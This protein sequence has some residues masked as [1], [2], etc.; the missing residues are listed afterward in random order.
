MQANK[1][2]Y[3]NHYF[4]F[5]NSSSQ[6]NGVSVSDA[7]EITVLVASLGELRK[8]K[9]KS[10]V[11]EI[12]KNWK[13]LSSEF[14][15]QIK[16]TVPNYFIGK[17][18]EET[19][20]KYNF[21]FDIN[22]YP[23]IIQLIQTE[24]QIMGVICLVD[25]ALTTDLIET[26]KSYIEFLP[27]VVS[28]AC[29]GI[30]FIGDS[31]DTP[32]TGISLIHESCSDFKAEIKEKILEFSG[33]IVGSLSSMAD[34]VEKITS[35][36]G[37]SRHGSF[38]EPQQS[39]LLNSNEVVNKLVRN[40]CK[41][42]NNEGKG[43]DFKIA[44]SSRMFGTNT[45]SPSN[46]ADEVNSNSYIKIRRKSSIEILDPF[47]HDDLTFKKSQGR[48]KKLEGDLLLMSGRVT[49]AVAAFRLSIEHSVV[50]EDYVWQA[51][52]LESYAASLFILL[53]RKTERSFIIAIATCPPE[54]EIDVTVTRNDPLGIMGT[55]FNEGT[56]KESS[57]SKNSN[58]D[59]AKDFTTKDGLIDLLKEIAKL[60]SISVLSYEKSELFIPQL[61]S[62][63]CMKRAILQFIIDQY[64]TPEA[65]QDLIDK[66]LLKEIHTAFSD[67][68]KFSKKAS[69]PEKHYR[70]S[71]LEMA[72][73]IHRGWTQ[74]IMSLELRELMRLSATISMLFRF[75]GYQRKEAFFLRQF[76][77]LIQP[78]LYSNSESNYSQLTSQKKDTI[79]DYSVQKHII[80]CLG[81]VSDLY[82]V[83]NSVYF[84]R[85]TTTFYQWSFWNNSVSD[86]KNILKAEKSGTLWVGWYHL[87]TDILKECIAI[88]E[89]VPS[90]PHA[91][92]SAFRLLRFL[93][94][95]ENT[96]EKISDT[97]KL[98]L[99]F[100]IK[101]IKTEQTNLL[102]YLE[103]V[104]SL[105]HNRY[106]L[107]ISHPLL[108]HKKTKKIDFPLLAAG[109]EEQ[110]AK[111]LNIFKYIPRVL[112]T[113]AVVVGDVF[114]NLLENIQPHFLNSFNSG[115]CD[116]NTSGKNNSD[117][118]SLFLYNPGNKG[119]LDK[120]R[121]KSDSFSTL[122]V[123]E[124]AYFSVTFKNPFSIP[125][126]LNNVQLLCE[127][128]ETKGQEEGSSNPS[129]DS[130][131]SMD[132]ENDY[133]AD[134]V[135]SFKSNAFAKPILS[136]FTLPPSSFFTTTLAIIPK[137]RGFGLILGVR[138]T[139]FN[140]VILNCL[141][142]E[143]PPEDRNRNHRFQ[144]V[145]R[146]IV[147]EYPSEIIGASNDSSTLMALTNPN[148]GFA[149]P[150]TVYPPQP[151]LDITIVGSENQLYPLSS[152]QINEGETVPIYVVLQNVGT[153]P[154]T[155]FRVRFYNLE[156]E[157]IKD[158]AE[159][160]LRK[161]HNPLESLKNDIPSFSASKAEPFNGTNQENK[162]DFEDF[163]LASVFK[164]MPQG[165]ESTRINPGQTL[166]LG[167]TVF[168]HPFCKGVLLKLNYGY[169]DDE[170]V[171][172]NQDSKNPSK[173]T[174][175]KS[176]TYSR[177]I[178]RVIDIQLSKVL[179]PTIEYSMCK[180]LPLP[181]GLDMSTEEDK[182]ENISSLELVD[183]LVQSV[184]L[185]QKRIS[186]NTSRNLSQKHSKCEND[187]KMIEI[188]RFMAKYFC[189]V[190]FNVSNASTSF[191]EVS[192]QIE[193][194]L[195]DLGEKKLNKSSG[196]DG[197]LPD[198]IIRV[199]KVVIP[200]NC[201]NF[202]IL[203]PISRFKLGLEDL[204]DTN[205]SVFDENGNIKFKDYTW[206]TD[207]TQRYD[208][209]DGQT[210]DGSAIQEAQDGISNLNLDKNGINGSTSSTENIG[211]KATSSGS[212]SSVNDHIGS[213]SL[214][215][216]YV[217]PKG[218]KIS[219]SQL[220]ENRVYSSYQY[221]LMKSIRIKYNLI[222]YNR[223]G[224]CNPVMFVKLNKRD[225]PLLRLNSLV[226]SSITE[227]KP[228]YFDFS[229]PASK[230]E[231]KPLDKAK[232]KPKKRNSLKGQGTQNEKKPVSG[233]IVI[234]PLRMSIKSF[235]P[236]IQEK[237]NSV[238]EALL[239]DSSFSSICH[240]MSHVDIYISIKN[241]S[242]SRKLNMLFNMRMLYPSGVELDENSLPRPSVDTDYNAN[243]LSSMKN[244]DSLDIMNKLL[245][246]YIREIKGSDSYRSLASV[247]NTLSMGS[248][249]CIAQRTRA[250]FQALKLA[251]SEVPT[252]YTDNK[253]IDRRATTQTSDFYSSYK[254]P[255][256]LKPVSNRL[257]IISRRNMS[258]AGDLNFDEK[259]PKVLDSSSEF[260]D[261]SFV[262]MRPRYIL[263][264]QPHS[265]FP[266]SNKT[267]NVPGFLNLSR[268]SIGNHR[269]ASSHETPI[270]NKK[271][272]SNISLLKNTS[273]KSPPMF[274]DPEASENEVNK[275]LVKLK[276]TKT[277]PNI[278]WRDI[279]NYK[280]PRI[281]SESQS[282]VLRLP[283]FV[284]SSGRYV[285]EYEVIPYN[286]ASKSCDSSD[287][288]QNYTEKGKSSGLNLDVEVKNV[289]KA[290]QKTKPQNEINLDI[291]DDFLVSGITSKKGTLTLYA[292]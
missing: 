283:V 55:I 130:N 49:E 129:S 153:V 2:N 271:N 244:L 62:E 213:S 6:Y 156:P 54:T 53:N 113:D 243:L 91:I 194:V 190:S 57:V 264:E 196:K 179:V 96:I 232:K 234:N 33:N 17:A 95:I 209:E 277:I 94:H 217:V 108:S 124:T 100:G 192:F 184:S 214:S 155:H 74:S 126:F 37:N 106:H 211:N 83:D 287:K 5:E 145:R 216:Q 222:D 21:I 35:K 187:Y 87:Q 250:A 36:Y 68:R 143:M 99:G 165:Q 273:N 204:K 188:Q 245:S 110:I 189:I 18:S 161:K 163:D 71:A 282:I 150:V 167:F 12:K 90:Y 262:Y 201:S 160:K 172:E 176:V 115:W 224:F 82:N 212:K 260:Q 76:L 134:H 65:L 292:L 93:S 56:S 44:D 135:I 290:K 69:N 97:E 77:L 133:D 114:N 193:L 3:D 258:L 48:I 269:P 52:A 20:I 30:D 270:L 257:N 223:I 171:D 263:N 59:Q 221:F 280:L 112:G 75:S 144:R 81:S 207:L 42:S 148:A 88:A 103:R 9:W 166:K 199:V 25:C 173:N 123:D 183:M 38:E 7:G 205:D 27:F 111:K 45:F 46:M 131:D 256:N 195:P 64:T 101:K 102:K 235:S 50:L 137:C 8:G 157:P 11:S 225:I 255:N 125:L 180:I 16:S 197:K 60:Y 247:S 278:F 141:L 239:L 284:V 208:L 121:A 109:M 98:S 162:R 116:N 117:S 281:D 272:I 253:F 168:G 32:V 177:E 267:K 43:F 236:Y 175:L 251:K 261:R 238:S 127:F 242:T 181:L 154:V 92:A 105:Y 288:A 218:P 63:S 252:S 248:D 286:A 178:T 231:I 254:I 274:S 19:E 118:Q 58:F 24:K 268:Y 200:G 34:I 285:F 138:F 276:N 158:K 86:I 80:E 14:I 182:I 186:G 229:I 40:I 78:L 22:T 230:G 246:V 41:F 233:P 291:N 142:P 170:A 275:G 84:L 279:I 139:I 79:I 47:D 206:N 29:L 174:K 132:F 241:L 85:N 61:H 266:S 226:T 259:I 72:S 249:F 169:T 10:W 219:A 237:L 240:S 51:S 107:Q 151:K 4:D 122:V 265:S 289:S 210:L 149:V 227:I 147:S 203:L 202:M 198:R 1:F 26:Y 185:W 119:S 70:Q 136:S 120:K 67:S 159:D 140:N 89:S 146:R 104:L 164:K 215:Q 128:K 152:I 39:I 15:S 31:N 73:W 220:L 66:I 191:V 23:P 228:C 13:I 28:S